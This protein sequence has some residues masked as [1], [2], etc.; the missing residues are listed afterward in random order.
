MEIS[1]QNLMP[2]ALLEP[3]QERRLRMNSFV[4]AIFWIWSI[5]SVYIHSQICYYW[6]FSIKTRK[7]DDSKR[8]NNWISITEYKFIYLK[9]K[10]SH[11]I[12]TGIPKVSNFEK[13]LTWKIFSTLPLFFK[14][15]LYFSYL[16]MLI[17]YLFA[18]QKSLFLFFK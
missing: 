10:T 12:L 3:K 1:K 2:R 13:Y 9:N 8:N 11:N 14:W 15:N 18:Y 6:Q 7:I 16:Y 17:N 4:N 5:W